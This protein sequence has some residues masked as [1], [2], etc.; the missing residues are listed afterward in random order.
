[1]DPV[2]HDAL[3]RQL[4][5]DVLRAN[6]YVLQVHPVALDLQNHLH[7]LADQ[8]ER[9]LPVADLLLKHNKELGGLHGRQRDDVVL[10]RGVDVL[11]AAQLESGLVLHQV[12]VE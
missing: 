1:M 12:E 6:E 3:L 10:E 4:L 7:H 11:C 8:A 9:L 2:K 5:A